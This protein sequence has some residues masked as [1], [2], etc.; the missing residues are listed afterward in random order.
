M[1]NNQ[2]LKILKDI[3]KNGK[4][5]PWREKKNANV[6]Y[7]EILSHLNYKKALNVKICAE[8]L[9]FDRTES[10]ELKLHQAWFCKS[11]LC[12]LCNW[13]RS[14]KHSYQVIQIL[15][16]ALK[17]EPKARFL[18]WTLTVKNAYD[19]EELKASLSEMTQAFNR[20][21]K[22]KKVAKNLLGFVRATEITINP[23]DN[24]YNQHMHILV[25]VKPTYFKNSENYVSQKELTEFWQRALKINYVPVVNI[26]SVKPNKNKTYKTENDLLG[27][28]YETAKYSVKD[29]EYL[30][31]DFDK[32]E[33]RVDDLER[34]LKYKRMIS[35][36]GILKEIKKEFE[37]DDVEDANLIELDSNQEKEK[38]TGEIVVAFWNWERK[39]YFLR[40]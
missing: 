26:K 15:D 24:S 23:T 10:G 1:K 12:P 19:W 18:F 30:T 22:Y 25:M 6:K 4:E 11:K 35:F 14:M 36:G 5:M 37:L 34:A 3:R 8:V 38:T 21:V 16:E 2:E 17:R 7:S 33:K 9:H 29:S 32:N 39:N 40:E 27:A 13:R 28:I 31:D 20:L